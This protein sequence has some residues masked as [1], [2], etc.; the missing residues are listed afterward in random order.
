MNLVPKNRS[1]ITP[2]EFLGRVKT[3]SL[4][5]AAVQ[6]FHLLVFAQARTEDYVSWFAVNAIIQ[7]SLWVLRVA[8]RRSNSF[9]TIYWRPLVA[10]LLLSFVVKVYSRLPY[11]SSWF[12]EGLYATRNNMDLGVSGAASYFN[13][14]FY[15]LAIL[16]AFTVLPRRAYLVSM[17]CVVFMCLMDLVFIGTRNAPMFVLLFHFLT[18]PVKFTTKNVGISILL[19]FC[20]IG[21]FS[22]STVHRSYE[23]LEGDWDW[24]TTFELTGSTQVLKINRGVVVPLAQHIPAVLPAVF[25]SHY[26]AHSVAELAHLM[27]VR[28]E[29][30]FGGLP[31]ITDQLCAIG[32]G[33]RADSAWAIEVANP[34]AGVY[35]TIFASLFFDFGMAGA[36]L[37]WIFLLI[38]TLFVQLI[39]PRRLSAGLMLISVVIA[40][41]PI[42]NYLYNGLGFAQVLTLFLALFMIQLLGRLKEA[43]PKSDFLKTDHVTRSKGKHAHSIC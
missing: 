5:L 8:A 33:S 42:E 12:S 19:C 30:D 28:Q 35:Q 20:F 43:L 14:F 13:I 21:I 15:P 36:A 22:Y 23:S 38:L 11:I 40:V 3:F 41:G 32:M 4:G 18:L 2:K 31:Y 29:L 26:F 16:L 37:L 17:A 6:I 34:R 25:L 7:I 27:D 1:P 24:V 10:L 39:R 9:M